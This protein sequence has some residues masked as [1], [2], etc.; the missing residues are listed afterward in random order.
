ME[1]LYSQ[2]EVYRP[3]TEEDSVL[4]EVQ[5]GCS[6]G[7]CAFCDFGKDNFKIFSL[8]DIAT[9]IEILAEM[10]PDEE[11]MFFLGQN[12]LGIE[13]NYLEQVFLLVN[14]HMPK[15]KEIAMYA[16]ADDVLEKGLE[17]LKRYKELGLKELHIGLESG[18][19][20]ILQRMNKNIT[21][22]EYI[23]AFDLLDEAGI[24][25]TI[26]VIPG[27][28]GKEHS[29]E[30][31][32]DTAAV[33]NRCRPR[34]IWALDLY[35]WP[36]T[37]LEEEVKAG[38][39]TPMNHLETGEEQIY[40]VEQLRPTTEMYYMNTTFLGFYT[41]VGELFNGKNRLRSMMIKLFRQDDDIIIGGK[42]G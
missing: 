25:Y 9:K 6:Y 31:V 8:D 40:L 20:E 12:T 23:E 28:G 17:A 27:L 18:N 32:R 26:T 7:R 11:R 19:A 14:K 38:N 35:I 13:T 34:L 21:P 3:I 29:A 15:I 10:Y 1:L 33:I 30:H 39:F 4:L 22:E 2:R 37:P 36:G 24:D 42:N 5:Q 41:V 16:R